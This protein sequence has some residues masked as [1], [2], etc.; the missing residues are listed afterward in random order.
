MDPQFGRWW[1]RVASELVLLLGLIVMT[2]SEASGAAPGLGLRVTSSGVLTKNGAPYRGIGVNYYDAFIRTLRNPQDDS[3]QDGFAKLGA[4][5]IPFARFAAGGHRASDVQLYLTEKASYFQ[6][7]DGVVA[8]AEKAHVGLIA[9][10]FWSISAVSDA[11]HE[12]RER[13]GDANSE[14]R[15]LM[16]KYTQE[17]VSRYVNSPAIWG[18]E[19]SNELSLAVDMKPGA[20]A[21]GHALSYD[22]FRRAALDF[23]QVVREIDANRILLTGNSLPRAYAYHSSTAGVV[24]TDTEEQFAHILLRDNPDPFSPLCIHA[25]QA[26]VGHYFADRPVSF[27]QLLE[28]CM[29]IGQRVKKPVYLEEFIPL[30]KG[31]DTMPQR[32]EHEYFSGELAAI[33][34]SNVPLASVWEYDRKLTRD[35]FSLTFDNER[36]Y[37]LE[38]IA[39]A[40]RH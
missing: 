26:N 20:V 7:L 14:T 22:T 37:M 23:A 4:N 38:M 5:K 13:W 35:R 36:S 8:A 1:A 30:P 32:S 11:V 10:L 17:V 2:N 6:R 28:A 18:W 40:N 29:K 39:A 33:Q 21:P 25:S 15:K 16:R 3:Y 9:N 27:Q 31:A 12:P 34:K 24:R 19:F